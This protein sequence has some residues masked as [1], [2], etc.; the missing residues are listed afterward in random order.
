[1]QARLRSI[2]DFGN[3]DASTPRR[4]AIVTAI[5]ATLIVGLAVGCGSSNST[6][7]STAALSKSAYLTKANA[8]C[9]AGNEKQQADQKALGKNPSQAQITAYVTGTQVPDI[10]SQIDQVKALG[11]PSG[12]EAVVNKYLAT[13]QADLNKIKSDPSL[14]YSAKS[15][16]FA[17]FAAIAH[18]YG[19]TACAAGS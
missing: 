18:P 10:Q 1:V 6:T 14:A 3:N 9:K 12:D 17:D 8:I 16:P 2:F 7:T 4:R 19:L 5:A 11:A 13:A 15:D